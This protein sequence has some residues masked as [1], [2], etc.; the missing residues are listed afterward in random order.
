MTVECD[1]GMMLNKILFLTFL[2]VPE[3]VRRSTSLF[4]YLRVVAEVA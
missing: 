1:K 4:S 3:Q 2:F